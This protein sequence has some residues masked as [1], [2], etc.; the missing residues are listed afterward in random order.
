MAFD[1]GD[2]NNLTPEQFNGTVTTTSTVI[3][4]PNGNANIQYFSINNPSRGDRANG[5]NDVIYYSLDGGTTY[6]TLTRGEFVFLPGDIE[7]LRL[8]S[9][10]TNVNYEVVLWCP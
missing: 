7:D 1:D 9:S 4:A 5:F 3:I 6:Q 8:Q 2:L 10:G